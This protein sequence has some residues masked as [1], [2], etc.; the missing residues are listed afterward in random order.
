MPLFE[1]RW[2]RGDA[3]VDVA[4]LEVEPVD[5]LVDR[6]QTRNAI[7]WLLLDATS[8]A[9]P[10]V[11]QGMT[12]IQRVNTVGGVASSMPRS[13]PGEIAEVPYTAQYFFDRASDHHESRRMAARHRDRADW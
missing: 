6:A 5:Q 10:G 7:L 8:S 9:G 3:H 13:V 12:Q 1:R 11:F 2:L 4:I